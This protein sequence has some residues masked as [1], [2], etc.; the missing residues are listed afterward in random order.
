MQ[1][2][3]EP[4]PAFASVISQPF[5]YGQGHDA[6][7]G[8][9]APGLCIVG[10]ACLQPRAE[11]SP[12]LAKTYSTHEER[13]NVDE[14]EDDDELPIVH[15]VLEEIVEVNNEDLRAS[16]RAMAADSTEQAAEADG[17]PVEPNAS[18][19]AEVVS[20]LTDALWPDV[21]QALRPLVRR[22]VEA[23]RPLGP[24][25]YAAL[26]PA[27]CGS[28]SKGDFAQNQFNLETDDDW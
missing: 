19:R 11:T 24:D 17:V 25:L 22:V 5:E 14:E 8:P 26:E 20:I 12:S 18:E 16:W 21:V 9:T 28:G 27:H 2:H 23:S 3:S 15:G 1:T 4:N 6:S 13:M 10:R 7:D